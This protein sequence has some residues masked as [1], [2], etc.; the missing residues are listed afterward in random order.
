M[1]IKKF[2]EFKAPVNEASLSRVWQH[3]TKDTPFGVVSA[4][5]FELSEEENLKRH[6]ALKKKARE[7]GYGFIEQ[8][9]GYTYSDEAAGEKTFEERSLFIPGVDLEDL[10]KLGEEF[11]QETVIYKDA[12]RFDLVNC[13]TGETVI[14]FAK[15]GSVFT[16]DKEDLKNAWSQLLKTNS[17]TPSKSKMFAFKLQEKRV[18]SMADSL[19]ALK[20]KRG[21]AETAWVDVF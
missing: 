15:N 3:I 9:G 5:R 10:T 8:R 18:P 2:D 19:L 16:F 4:F 11:G 14:S 12:T 13:A 7:M 20:E 21:L 6:E 1:A 17:K